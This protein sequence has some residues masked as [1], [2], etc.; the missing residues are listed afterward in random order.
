MRRHRTLPASLFGLAVLSGLRIVAAANGGPRDPSPAPTPSSSPAPVEPPRGAPSVEPRAARP[1]VLAAVRRAPVKVGALGGVFAPPYSE[2]PFD[3][4]TEIENPSTT[5]LDATL[6]A[7]RDG[8]GVLARV[9]VE[10]ASGGKAKVSFT[11]GLGLRDGCSATRDRVHLE[12]K[13]ALGVVA[14]TVRVT[15]SCSFT[16]EVAD[17]NSGEAARRERRGKLSVTVATLATPQLACGAP[18]VVRAVVRNETKERVTGALGVDGFGAEGARPFALRA[19]A[20]APVE[21]TIPAFHGA[22]GA[23]ALAFDVGADVPVYPPV[24]TL[25]VSRACSLDVGFDAP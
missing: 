8:A 24:W 22:I 7:E 23:H 14:K 3:L 15:P 10:I 21:I 11:D 1:P 4:E 9:P 13:G 19:G 25:R 12:G 6:V 17:G 20:E 18:L 5:P 2:G 16:T